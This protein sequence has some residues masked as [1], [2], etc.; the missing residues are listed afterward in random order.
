MLFEKDGKIYKNVPAGGTGG[1]ATGWVAVLA[2]DG[3]AAAFI[4][5][6]ENAAIEESTAAAE[7]VGEEQPHV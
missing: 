2:S 1:G 4:A 7:T 3:E 6:R 5:E